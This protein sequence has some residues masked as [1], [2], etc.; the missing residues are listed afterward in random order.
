MESSEHSLTFFSLFLSAMNRLSWA[1][2]AVANDATVVKRVTF[3]PSFIICTLEV[4]TTDTTVAPVARR[5]QSY[6]FPEESHPVATKRLL[7]RGDGECFT[8]NSTPFSRTMEEDIN[9]SVRSRD[10]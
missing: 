5:R 8:R 6:L 9:G 7:E 4:A 10:M 3:R 1:G 2:T